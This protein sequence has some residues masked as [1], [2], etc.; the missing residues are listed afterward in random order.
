MRIGIFGGSFDPVHYGHLLLAEWAREQAELDEV[1]L[2]PA[3]HAPHKSVGPHTPGEARAAMLELACAEND[4]IRVSRLELERG[5]ISYTAE[6]LAAIHALQPDDE[7]FL[8]MG[9]DSLFDLPNWRE[10]RLICELATP[11]V[12]R[13]FGEPEL[14]FTVLSGIASRDVIDQ[15]TRLQLQMPVLDYSSTE[16]RR[17]VQTGQSLRYQTPEAVIEYIARQGLYR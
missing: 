16:L 11:L 6:T 10:P 5:G 7:L 14:D 2:M 3:F 4:A 9:A 1:W 15:A 8:L 12:A 17:R 13:R